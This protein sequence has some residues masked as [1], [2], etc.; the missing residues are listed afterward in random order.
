MI[1]LGVSSGYPGYSKVILRSSL[2][3]KNFKPTELQIL[4]TYEKPTIFHKL[5]QWKNYKILTSSYSFGQQL[6]NNLVQIIDNTKAV[7]HN[8]WT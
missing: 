8:S 1:K 4:Y 2:H 6:T 5:A 3:L 7:N